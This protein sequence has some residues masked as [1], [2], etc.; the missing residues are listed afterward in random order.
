[1]WFFIIDPLTALV[2]E[3]DTSTANDILNDFMAKSASLCNE[4][5]VTMFMYSHV[6]PPQSGL[7][8]DRGGEVLSSQ[9]TGSRAMEKW[10]HYGW[11]IVRNRYE[12]NPIKRNT[13]EQVLLFDREFGEYGRFKCYY[14]A[15]KNDWSEITQEQYDSMVALSEYKEVADEF[16]EVF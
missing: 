2:A 11:G 4:L 1:M 9:F 13:A 12:E 15:V 7:P 14:D 3:A 16:D 8:H 6:N 10:A 5:Q